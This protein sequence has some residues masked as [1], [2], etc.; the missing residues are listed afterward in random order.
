MRGFVARWLAWLPVCTLACAAQPTTE[1]TCELGDGPQ[2]V[3]TTTDFSTGAVSVVDTEQRCV[4]R[5]V[6]LASTD[7]I[8]IAVDGQLFVVNRHGHDFVDELDPG[9]FELLSQTAIEVE[10]AVSTNPHELAL[11]PDGLAHVTM[12]G[13]SEVQVLDLEAGT[14]EDRIDLSE[15]ADPDGIAETSLVFVRG[16]ELF[17]AVQRLD[18]TDGWKQADADLL[19]VV[20]LT[21]REPVD[22]DP[23]SA[24]LQGIELL[25]RWP[26]QWRR[27]SADTVLILGSGIQRVNL[28]TRSV[29]WVVDEDSMAQVGIDEA[30][31]PQSFDV[32][33]AGDLVF[34]AYT[35]GFEEVRIYRA[36]PDDD[37]APVELVGGLNSVERTLTVVGD[38][39]WFGDTTLGASGMR[40]FDMDGT[41]LF[42]QALA[43]GLAPYAVSKL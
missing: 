19:V 35:P 21:T 37:Y 9:G 20:D 13:A 29:E 26:K 34:A 12:Y 5:D 39:I 15:L 24:G 31:L 23:D 3:V 28:E 32:S 30:D 18:R 41:A 7:A 42:E 6:A 25:G 17:V 4:R 10:G 33:E 43:T 14:V 38:E 11:G 40:A 36:S 2:I 8:P 27:E 22:L 16:G 1:G